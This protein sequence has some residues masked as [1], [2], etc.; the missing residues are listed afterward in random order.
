MESD[1]MWS[2]VSCFFHLTWLF[3]GHPCSMYQYF[4][5]FITAEYII[6][7]SEYTTFCLIHSPGN[8]CLDCFH[9]LA[10]I[11]TMKM[12]LWKMLLWTFAFYFIYIYRYICTPIYIYMY[13][14]F[15]FS[16]VDC[17]FTWQIYVLHFKKLLCFWLW[18][19]YLCPSKFLRWNPTSR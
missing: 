5:F 10:I 12:L 13:I 4:V 18:S 17:W 7:V 15:H 6:T 8:G 11:V 2:F 14:C 1:N 9:F 3:R 16:W 19:E